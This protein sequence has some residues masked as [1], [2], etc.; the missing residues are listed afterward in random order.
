MATRRSTGL[1]AV[2]VLAMGV[3]VFDAPPAATQTP[4]A[5]EGPPVTEAPPVAQTP[6]VT[7][8]PMVTVTP[9]VVID[10]QSVTITASGFATTGLYEFR[11][12][13]A[14][15]VPSPGPESP[16]C[17]PLSSIGSGVP[18]TTLTTPVYQ[19]FRSGGTTVDCAAE[20]G[21]CA[22]GLLAMTSEGDFVEAWAP[23]T[24]TP[25]LSAAPLRGLADGDVVAVAATNLPTGTWTVAQCGLEGLYRPEAADASCGPSVPLVRRGRRLVARVTVHDP[26]VAT[27]GTETICRFE[28]CALVV[29]AADGSVRTGT[30]LSFGEPVLSTG[31]RSVFEPGEEVPVTLSDLPGERATVRQC[32]GTPGESTCDDGVETPLD[33]WGYAH[34]PRTVQRTFT[35]SDGTEVDCIPASCVLV[36]QVDGEEVARWPIIVAFPATV[37]LTPDSGLLEGQPMTLTATGLPPSEGFSAHR[38]A[39]VF[40]FGC[41][42]IGSAWSD[43]SGALTFEV[44]AAQRVGDQGHCGIGCG[45]TLRGD[46]TIGAATYTMAEGTATAAPSTG[47]SDGDVVRVSGSDLLPSYVGPSYG[48][49]RTGDWHVLQCEI[50]QLDEPDLHAVFDHCAAPVAVTVTGSTAGVDLVV[51]ASMTT[52][53]GGT[54]DC[55]RSGAC[56]VG[57]YRLESNGVSTLWSAPIEIDP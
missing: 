6:P 42:G 12:C 11:L 43:A 29:R 8:T 5:T 56:G 25:M 9:G 57:F 55:T 27:D 7:E 35:A 32:A 36:A 15:E 48:P 45:V 52:M 47:L 31:W 22:V 23:L 26:V 53:L 49:Y 19:Q 2:F 21:G 41:E 39:Y 20:P 38:C 30:F 16:T 4:P 28:G 50:D 18:P 46:Y 37:A 17:R 24:F 40:L 10:R 13:R 14:S 1:V 33:Q 44:S 51:H 3:A 54:V 34:V